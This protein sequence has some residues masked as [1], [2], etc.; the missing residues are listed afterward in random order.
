MATSLAHAAQPISGVVISWIV[1]CNVTARRTPKLVAKDLETWPPESDCGRTAMD[2]C[3]LK[4]DVPAEKVAVDDSSYALMSPPASTSSSA[5]EPVEHVPQAKF[6]YPEAAWEAMDMNFAPPSEFNELDL[7]GDSSWA[8]QPFQAMMGTPDDLPDNEVTF[9]DTTISFNASLPTLQ[10]YSWLF[11]NDIATNNNEPLPELVNETG[12][13]SN[14]HEQLPSVKASVG[15]PSGTRKSY[16]PP[17]SQDNLLFTPESGRSYTTR[18]SPAVATSP[19]TGGLFNYTSPAVIQAHSK[20]FGVLGIDNASLYF[21]SRQHA[22]SQNQEGSSLI[23]SIDSAPPDAWIR[24]QPKKLPMIS[25]EARDG[26][27]Q[28][29]S[30]TRP[31]RMD[32]TEI[33]PCDPLLSL[34]ALQC[35]SDLFFIHFNSTYPLI[36]PG[37][38]S[39]S[40]VHPLK[41]MSIILLGATY[42]DTRAHSLAI[43]L[44]DMMRPLIHSHKEFGPRPSFWM[45]QTI[46]LVECF[47]KSRAG[48]RQH[49]VSNIYHG[50]QINLLRRSNCHNVSNPTWDENRESLQEYWNAA[51]QAEEKRRLAMISFMWDTQ[52]ATFFAQILCMN[53]SELKVALPW[54][55][56]IW[57]AETAEDWFRLMKNSSPPPQFLTIL[58]RYT[59][60][61]ASFAPL[62]LNALSRVLVLHGLMSLSWDF[63]RRE[64]TALT[65]DVTPNGVRWQTKISACYAKWKQDFDRYTRLVLS[66]LPTDSAEHASFQRYAV[67]NSAVYHTAQVVLEVEIADLQIRGGAKH[68]TG[69]QVTDL[70]RQRSQTRIKD[71]VSR[72]GGKSAAR[73]TWHAA[74]L[75]RD[76]IR[77]L[78]NWAVDEMIHFPWCLYLA[79]LTCWTAYGAA[80]EMFPTNQMPLLVDTVFPDSGEADNDNDWDSRTDMKALISALT[81]LDPSRPTFVKD[82]WAVSG[83]YRP[84]GLLACMAKHLGT[85][86]WAVVKEGMKV[87]RELV[88][89]ASSDV[90]I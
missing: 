35:Y 10:Y 68:I 81:R 11:G 75:I 87:L 58:Q 6:T 37:T 45:L 55:T 64:Q 39:S 69:R 59:D 20:E 77:K 28:L 9:P 30:Q 2:E 71:F 1:M 82:I 5:L 48:E 60:P 42:S 16:L 89:N 70:D 38:F 72:D 84:H 63:R 83:K 90:Q 53:A 24:T 52:H 62:Y 15:R 47:G 79:T 31:T 26:L 4:A 29:I 66:S 86:R 56:A 43:C 44:H 18:S 78:D 19:E 61:R 23:G 25:I 73:A 27:L 57:E 46:L 13:E 12:F 33:S 50:L 7:W 76:G 3:T 54:D 22:D 88:N 74:H 67:A 80:I 65:R 21:S 51:V 14:P 8:N 85:I 41:L 17:R 36:H 40:A 34:A 32:Q 49:D